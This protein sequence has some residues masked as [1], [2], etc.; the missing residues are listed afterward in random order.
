MSDE[1]KVEISDEMLRELL[2]FARAAGIDFGV[3][4][5]EEERPVSPTVNIKQPI[6]RQA[7]EFATVVWDQGL[8]RVRDRYVTVEPDGELLEM[9]GKRFVGWVDQ[10]CVVCKG[11]DEDRNPKVGQL[12]EQGAKLVL[13]QDVFRKMIPEI[14]SVKRARLPVFLPGDK[15]GL[16]NK[17]Y[18]K[19]S[20]IYVARNAVD[21]DETMSLDEALAEV[22]DL[23]GEFPYRDEGRSL[24]VHL[25]CCLGVYCQEMLPSACACP[26][27]Q[28]T[29]NMEG[30]G[31]SQLART[32][33]LPIYGLEGY[34][35]T[36]FDKTDKFRE[37]LNSLALS[38]SGYMFL[39]DM[40]GHLDSPMLNRWVTDATWQF[41]KFHSQDLL[42]VDKRCVTMISDNGVTLSDDLIRRTL[43]VAFWAEEAGIDREE[44][45]RRVIT[46]QWLN[47]ADVRARFQS[48]WWT[49]VRFWDQSGRPR[50]PR[51]IG[52]LSEWC[53][54]IGGILH[55]AGF[56]DPFQKA[57][58]L[59]G[60]DKM[61]TEFQMLLEELVKRYQPDP[62][63]R[64]QTV[65]IAAIARELGIY[66]EVIGELD[67]VRVD[68][69]ANPG[70]FYRPIRNEYGD[71]IRDVDELTEE[72]RN[73]QA[74]RNL[75]PRRQL[76]PFSKKL[77]KKRGR[78]FVV[79][80]A[81][82]MFGNREERQS[83]YAV[84][85]INS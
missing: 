43:I 78:K 76:S 42:R 23:F 11:F 40:K 30:S 7:L 74:A 48:V 14:K 63:V 60:G 26:V 41:R 58:L 51:R 10:F 82:Y 29:A 3:Q 33:I 1:R 36:T 70:K 85:R 49:L 34:G 83:T 79:D 62:E 67:G 39:D 44:K 59:D 65:E 47:T 31:K 69:D 71:V 56:E 77:K 53:D 5:D 9:D 8:F 80:G 84:R 54:L 64:V 55:A 72:E 52:S 16:L 15:I 66:V 37:E 27:F 32:A 22:E 75:D 18:N 12:T 17:G 25:A 21:V 45:L 68:M 19:D 81:T 20:Q 28:Y 38:R 35:S 4:G 24:A 61:R 50:S 57:G 46:D 73:Y 2:P 13:A 6:S